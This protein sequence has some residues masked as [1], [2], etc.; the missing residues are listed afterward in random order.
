[1]CTSFTIGDAKTGVIYARTWE[2]T[3][4]LL[5]EFM[6]VPAGTSL[7]A[8]DKKADVGHG[9]L[10]WEAKYDTVGTNALKLPLMLDGVNEKG[11]SYGSLNFPASAGFPE[12]SDADQSKSLCTAELGLF[13]LTTCADVKEV[14][15]VLP[16][17][18]IQAVPL[19][20][21]GNVAPPL[22]YTIHDKSGESIV[23]EYVD[24]E[25][26]VYDNPTTVMTNEPSFPMQL[27]NLA[28][29]Q[30]ITNFPAPPIEVEG[31]SY[32]AASSG[33]GTVGL[34]GGFIAT[35]RFV[36]AFW[37]S[38][39]AVPHK[40]PEEGV[41]TARHIINS[42]DIPPGSVMTPGGT[43]ESGGVTGAEITQWTDIIDLENSVIYASS[44]K[45]PNLVR[46]E[47]KK[48][49]E[50]ADGVTYIPMPESDPIPELLPS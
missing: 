7:T 32:A 10:T 29:Y 44:Y 23:V 50:A 42:F 41:Q 3:L 31:A 46:V 35:S 22:H 33:E 5:T 12:V 49:C 25:L 1:M 6:V 15:K 39:F 28:Q 18:L 38:H 30:S 2:F 43:G 45:H 36:R 9:G 27:S 20:Q 34:P 37:Y 4:D 8:T 14:R 21:Y 11:L 16:D 24:G 17:V 19:K 26:N 47:V 13:L 40:T 48:A